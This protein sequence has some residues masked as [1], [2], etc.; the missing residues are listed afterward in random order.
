MRAAFFTCSGSVLTIMPVML[1]FIYLQRY[2]I[3][4]ITAGGLNG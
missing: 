3:Q 4:G 2:Y 1:V